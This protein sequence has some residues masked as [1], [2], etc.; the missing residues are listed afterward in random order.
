MKEKG[1]VKDLKTDDDGGTWDNFILIFKIK[2]S[3]CI[4]MDQ[5]VL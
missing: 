2:S 3:L 4:K 5:Q 1:K